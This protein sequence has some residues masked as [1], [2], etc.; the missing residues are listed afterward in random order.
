[1][2]EIRT[3][4]GKQLSLVGL[5]T[6]PFQGEE[7]ATIIRKAYNAGYNL[8]DTADDYRG[9]TGIGLALSRGWI[10]REEIFLQTKISNDTAYADEPLAGVYF[11][12]LSKFM[13]RH[14]VK[15]IVREKVNTSL[16]KM[17]T[18]YLDSVLIHYPYPGYYEDIWNCLREMR[19]AGVIRYIGVSNCAVR[20]LECLK[21]NGEVPSINEVYVSPLGVKKDLLDYARDNHILV[22][23]YSPLMDLT[24]GSL[25]M[26]IINP[27]SEKYHKAPSQI[28]LRWNIER[29]CIPLAKTK[30]ENRMKDNLSIDDFQLTNEEIDSISSMNRDYQI[31]TESKIC[32]GL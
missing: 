8:I 28:V 16:R 3:K 22:M 19:D 10:E 18:D 11:N 25:D 13:A 6:F 30:N 12:P 7:M 4:S 26:N 9:E 17:N 29:G 24:R 21:R 23:T 27:L 5:G 14:S 1:M 31:L 20:H 32:P 2:S 15:D